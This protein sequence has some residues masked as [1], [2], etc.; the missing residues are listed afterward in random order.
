MSELPICAKLRREAN[1]THEH[2]PGLMKDAAAII[3]ELVGAL[4][5][6]LDSLSIEERY[7]ERLPLVGKADAAL[8]KVHEQ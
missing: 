1:R 8:S 5:D 7:A 2:V 4:Q 6:L 3:E